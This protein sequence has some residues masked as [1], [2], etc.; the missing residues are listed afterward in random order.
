MMKPSLLIK[1]SLIAMVPLLATCWMYAQSSQAEFSVSA[2]KAAR[3]PERRKMADDFL[4]KYDAK[5]LTVKKI[6]EL[7]GKPDYEYAV[8][9][10]RIN[11]TDP[12]LISTSSDSE[13]FQDLEL[14]VSFQQG[15]VSAVGLNHPLELE[16]DKRFDSVQW[17]ASKPAERMR[18]AASLMNSGILRNK[19]KQEVQSILGDADEKS[20]DNNIEI[21]YDLGLRM[22]DHMYLVFVVSPD[23]KILDAKIVEH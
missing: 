20:N 22:I 14:L 10:Y 13:I 7:L 2:W 17:K 4:K 11:T 15:V 12:K 16:E 5:S 6:Q 3:P 1:V 8:W 18:M 23:R 9:A 21:G 19:T